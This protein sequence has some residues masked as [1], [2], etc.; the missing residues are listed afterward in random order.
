MLSFAQMEQSGFISTFWLLGVSVF[1]IKLQQKDIGQY[2][3]FTQLQKAIWQQVCISTYI[4]VSAKKRT[5]RETERSCAAGGAFSWLILRPCSVC[6]VCIYGLNFQML[7]INVK[8]FFAFIVFICASA[9]DKTSCLL[10]NNVTSSAQ[11]RSAG[12]QHQVSHVWRRLVVGT[13]W[14]HSNLVSWGT[15][16]KTKIS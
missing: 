12:P 16:P 3:P 4:C 10:T 5:G 2:P 6:H 1:L 13:E 8:V 14:H 11:R 7:L 9:I 15:A